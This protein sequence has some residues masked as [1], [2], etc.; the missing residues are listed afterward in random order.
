MSLP[1]ALRPASARWRW[2][3]SAGALPRLFHTGARAGTGTSAGASWARAASSAPPPPRASPTA[4]TA[5]RGARVRSGKGGRGARVR[6]GRRPSGSPGPP[7]NSG[8]S[9]PLAPLGARTTSLPTGS[10]LGARV[11]DWSAPWRVS[12][13]G[14]LGVRVLGANAPHPVVGVA[15]LRQ[16]GSADAE[17]AG[18]AG[19]ALSRSPS[20]G[21]PPSTDGPHSGTPWAPLTVLGRRAVTRVLV[22]TARKAQY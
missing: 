11:A 22:Q 3:R 8:G 12:E 5:L 17:E 2:R 6:A 4:R 15:R 9:L 7:S 1:S 19:P 10:A 21:A 13:R 20:A 14:E 18:C 16:A